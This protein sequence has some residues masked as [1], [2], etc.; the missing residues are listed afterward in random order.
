MISFTHLAKNIHAADFGGY[1]D[2]ILDACCQNIA[3]SD[4]IWEHVVEM[5]TL[6]VS[7]TQ[8]GNPRNPWYTNCLYSST[9]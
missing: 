2:V 4:E 8:R 6:L 5:S 9:S 1:E 3:S 7:C